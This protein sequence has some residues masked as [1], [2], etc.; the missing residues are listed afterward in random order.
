MVCV[1]AVRRAASL[2]LLLALAAGCGYRL[3]RYEG[4]LG[5]ARRIAIHNLENDSFE[6]GV[7]SL[8]AGALH[9]EFLRRGALRVVDDPEAADLVLTGRVASLQTTRRSFSSIEFALEYEVRMVLDLSVRRR[10]G[11]RVKLGGRSLRESELYLTSADLEVERKNR[12]EA[13]RRLATLL[14]GRVH[15]ALYERIAP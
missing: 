6:P 13:L 7:G 5:D 11:T 2:L 14:A 3:V 1:P 15:D 10:D 8:V 12:E 4:A 9:R